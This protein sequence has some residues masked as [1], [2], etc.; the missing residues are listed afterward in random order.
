MNLQMTLLYT[1]ETKK[2]TVLYCNF[3]GI[4]ATTYIHLEARLVFF[5]SQPAF[6]SFILH[7]S[8][9]ECKTPHYCVITSSTIYHT[10]LITTQFCEATHTLS[11]VCLANFVLNSGSFW[12]VQSLLS[13]ARILNLSF[14]KDRNTRTVVTDKK[15]LQNE[16]WLRIYFVK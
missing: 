6:W 2:F 12:E 4:K 8:L 13:L 9:I 14:S 1:L 3:A 10:P 15:W 11:Q 7:S 16:S 5:A